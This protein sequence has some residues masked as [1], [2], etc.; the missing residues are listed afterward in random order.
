VKCRES[1]KKPTGTLLKPPN[2][3]LEGKATVMTTVEP[4]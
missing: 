1:K 2:V 4:A 3:K